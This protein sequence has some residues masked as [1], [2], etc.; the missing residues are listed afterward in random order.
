MKTI[1]ELCDEVRKTA[2][3]IHVYHGHRHLEK[4]YENAL[5]NRLRKAGIE[6][7]QQ[8]PLNVYDEDETL[9]GEY[10]ADLLVEGRLVVE[11][12]AC[13]TTADEHIA[14]ILGYLKSAKIDDG[15][16]INFGSYKFQIKKYVMSHERT[17][18]TQPRK[19]SEFLCCFFAFFAFLCGK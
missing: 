11:L 4:V 6:V 5:V 18:G 2:Y 13:R 8:H 19:L 10:F 7:K 14:Q 3:A 15:L 9:I 16:L 12:K 17:Q 1:K